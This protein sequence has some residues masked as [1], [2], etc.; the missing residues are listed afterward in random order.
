MTPETFL[1]FRIEREEREGQF[2]VRVYNLRARKEWK[3]LVYH[4]RFRT[5]DQLEE[6][7][8]KFKQN[9]QS[10]QNLK[11]ERKAERLN[12]VNPA[13]VDDILYA[14][15]GYEQT[16]IDFYQV[17]AVKG[18]SVVVRQI[19]AKREDGLETGNSMADHCMAV[20]DAFVGE[21]MTKRVGPSSGGYAININDY[22]SAWMWDGK[23]KYRSWYA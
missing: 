14:S 12:F 9:R 17:T 11:D 4:F 22:I 8:A 21:E 10:W 15:W 7:I 1:H 6:W 13:K 3:A 19:A 2:Y 16:N 18:K 20:K 5:M 23:P